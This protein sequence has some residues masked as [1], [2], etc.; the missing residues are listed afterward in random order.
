LRVPD[1]L[2]TDDVDRRREV[3]NVMFD[4]AAGDDD[5]RGCGGDRFISGRCLGRCLG[6]ESRR[7]QR[8]DGVKPEW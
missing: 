3:G 5:N 2:C 8:G 1:L 4:A 6:H 7:T